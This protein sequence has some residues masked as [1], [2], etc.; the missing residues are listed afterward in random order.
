MLQSLSRLRCWPKCREIA[1]AQFLFEPQG[2][3]RK[4][5]YTGNVTM[6]YE[7]ADPAHPATVGVEPFTAVEEPYKFVYQAPG[8]KPLLKAKNEHSD[9][10]VA[11]STVYGTSRVAAVAPGHGGD[12]FVDPNFHKFIGQTVKWVSGKE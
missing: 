11:W 5:E 3:I 10:V 9:E 2:A 12:I 6:T 1:A 7:A 8:A 4:S